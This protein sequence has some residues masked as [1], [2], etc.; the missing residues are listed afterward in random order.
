MLLKK[1]WQA[2]GAGLYQ[3]MEIFFLTAQTRRTPSV[4]RL[5]AKGFE[6]LPRLRGGGIIVALLTVPLGAC[7]QEAQ[8]EPKEAKI[9]SVEDLL[10]AVGDGDVKHS[11]DNQLHWRKAITCEG[12]TQQGGA[13][14]CQTLPNQKVK[15]ARGEDD[16]YFEQ[17]NENGQL[18]V[19]FDRDETTNFVEVAGERI[20]FDFTPRDYDTSRIDGL[21]PSQVSTFSDAQLK[22]IRASSARKKTG[23]ASRATQMGF[24]DGFIYPVKDFTK[25]T[26]FGAQRILNGEA[27]RPH[28]GVDL[29]APTGTPIYA[30]ADG[31]VSLA[32]DDL[33]FEG[34]MVL[35]DHGQGLIS[36]YLHTDEILVEPGQA[37]KQGEQIATVG[38]KGR[39]TG[40]HLCWR[41]KWRNRN[42]DP[43]LLTQWPS[44]G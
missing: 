13:V 43:E 12:V 11:H 6:H 24:K 1:A 22:R 29:A 32:D 34:A 17:A 37:V 10:A 35:L 39:S 8:K 44:E 21:P 30:P 41:L 2:E 7:A 14:L 4:L 5:F 38:S 9:E 16:F 26:N 42:L 28:Y 18:I 25:T 3:H 27:K 23:F 19:G 20:T 40:P 36:M 31:I 33:Y 15:I